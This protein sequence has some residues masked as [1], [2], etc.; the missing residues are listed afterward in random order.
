MLLPCQLSGLSFPESRQKNTGSRE[1]TSTESIRL[2]GV[3]LGIGRRMQDVS[4]IAE[5]EEVFKCDK[6]DEEFAIWWTYNYHVRK[7]NKEN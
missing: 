3:R 1:S 2:Y 4:I 7:I 5:I 6:C